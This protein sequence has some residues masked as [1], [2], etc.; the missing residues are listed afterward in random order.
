[1]F[2]RLVSC[3]RLRI[4][5]GLP[6][7]PPCRLTS[8]R[9]DW[10]TCRLTGFGSHPAY[11]ICPVF[12]RSAFSLV[13]ETYGSVRFGS[14]RM[15]VGS[16]SAG[17]GSKPVPVRFTV[18][19]T[20]RSTDRST[21]R[22]TVRSTDRSTVRSTDRSADRTRGSLRGRTPLIIRRWGV[23]GAQPPPLEAEGRL[24]GGRMPA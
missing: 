1:M 2:C 10:T 12:D 16:G 8:M 4:P 9:L 24:E 19:S 7:R 13:Q 23:G 17:S 21:V 11:Q 15:A 22:S 14:V 5:A 20:V 18:R 3:C 6:R